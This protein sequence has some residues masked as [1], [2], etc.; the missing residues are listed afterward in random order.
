[1]LLQTTKKWEQFLLISKAFDCLDHDL[2]L[3]KL[4]AYGISKRSIKLLYSYLRNRKHR[5]RI[6][7]HLSSWLEALLDVPQG[8]ILGPPLFNIFINDLFYIIK[9]ISNFADD[10]LLSLMNIALMRSPLSLKVD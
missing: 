9:D 4:S 6:G 2:L 7:S 10:I 8:S 3:A 1:M 5:V